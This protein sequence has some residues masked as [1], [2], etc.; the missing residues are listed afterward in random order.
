MSLPAWSILVLGWIAVASLSATVGRLVAEERG[1][2]EREGRIL[3]WVLGPLGVWI[4]SRLPYD[5]DSP[6]LGATLEDDMARSESIS[7][8]EEEHCPR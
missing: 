4:E 6:P 7:K 8:L 3:G 2:S 1:R 5:R